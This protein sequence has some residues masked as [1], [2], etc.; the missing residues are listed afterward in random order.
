MAVTF[1]VILRLSFLAPGV[2]CRAQKLTFRVVTRRTPEEGPVGLTR[3]V[4]RP[5]FE[6]ELGIERVLA[7]VVPADKAR[8]VAALQGEGRVVAMV[9][10][11]VNGAPALAQA[12]IGIAIGAGTD[13][14]IATAKVVLMRS[15]PLGVLVAHRLSSDRA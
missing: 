4:R 10:D 6:R 1:F 8:N 7:E 14:A 5:A 15:D 3:G 12:D 2:K 13:V 11:G 9:G